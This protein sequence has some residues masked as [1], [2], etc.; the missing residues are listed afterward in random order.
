M[1]VDWL[2]CCFLLIKEEDDE[3]F[4][5]KELDELTWSPWFSILICPFPWSLVAIGGCVYIILD[6][7]EADELDTPVPVKK[8]S[9]VGV[10]HRLLALLFVL[11]LLDVVLLFNGPLFGYC[12]D[13][14]FVL[15]FVRIG[16]STSKLI[17]SL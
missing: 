16:F 5:T 14:L 4:N 11:L 15:S 3:E 1:I 17:S 7:D 6:E 12:R 2:L 13:C 8:A 9:P 10:N